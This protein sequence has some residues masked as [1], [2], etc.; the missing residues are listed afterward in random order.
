MSFISKLFGGT[1]SERDIRSFKPLVDEINSIYASLEEQSLD[2][3]VGRL[4]EIRQEVADSREAVKQS[5]PDDAE[6]DEEMYRAEQDV[7]DRRMTEVFAIVKDAC[8][9]LMGQE[10]KV[11][12]QDMVWDMIPFDVQLFGAIVLHKG[13]I[14]EMKTGEGKTLVATMPIVLNALTG[15]GVHIITVNDYLAERD[16]QWMGQ[17]YQLLGL[18][19]GCIL[20]RMTPDE[21]RLIYACDITYGTNNEFGFDYLRDNMAVTPEDQ[22]QRGHAYGIVDEVDSVLIDE[23]RTPLIISGQVDSPID[24]Q[25]VEI[26]PKVQQL[27]RTQTNLVNSLVS[28]AEKEWEEDEYAAATKL[29]IASRGMP[30]NRKLMKMFQETG[31]QTAVRSVENDYMRD[32]KLHEL[33]EELYFFVDEKSHIIDLTDQGRV[34]ISPDNPDA[35]VIPD[36]GEAYHAIEN[37]PN[38][39]TEQQLVKKAEVQELHTQRSN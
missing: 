25:Y 8:R 13:R 31:V 21:R 32:K 10:F 1:K 37:E 34:H 36:L 16:S 35:F 33:D 3:L 7:L 29:L 38:L 18:S 30:K 28:E 4:K 5:M 19:V 2:Y 23:A 6:R 15:R 22:V 27:I 24:T 9:R 11:L 39:S 17:I 20:N 12:G 26:K 14:A